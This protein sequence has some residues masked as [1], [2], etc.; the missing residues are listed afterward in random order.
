MTEL[1]YPR[2]QFSRNVLKFARGPLAVLACIVLSACQPGAS[3]TAQTDV[4]FMDPVNRWTLLADYYGNGLTNWRTLPI[5][6][7]AMHDALNAARPTY[8]RWFPA[9]P[10]EPRAAGADPEAAMVAAARDVLTE[11]HPD[12]TAVTERTYRAAISRVTDGPAKDAGI[13]LGTAIGKAAVRRRVNDGSNIVRDFATSEAPGKWRTVPQLFQNSAINDTRPFL[14]RTIEDLP[15]LPPPALDSPLHQQQ[16]QETRRL[17]SVEHSTRTT[18][19]TNS[20]IFWARQ[21]SQRGFLRVGLNL[22]VSHPPRGG[23]F[24]EAR[25]LSQLTAAFADSAIFIWRAKEKYSFWR[26]ITELRVTGIDPAWS[27]LLNTPPFPE[28]P[29]GHASDCYVGAGVLQAVFA[30]PSEPI[31]YV[32]LAASGAL[33]KTDGSS[34]GMGQ[35]A[36]GGALDDIEHSFPSLSAA[37]EDCAWSR[38]WAGAHYWSSDVESKRVADLIVRKAV[39]S[40]PPLR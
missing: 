39:T 26:P 36:Q 27:P 37:A 29:S 28:H 16:L 20:A 17:G 24:E 25:I 8:A 11:L 5:M 10:D 35:H 19:Q 7:M 15:V 30:N 13:A 21:S 12:Q 6:Q 33:R 38:V 3:N 32:S 34:F 18:Q 31:R 9:E 14:F 22:M 4:P 23:M 1:T 2:T 40:V